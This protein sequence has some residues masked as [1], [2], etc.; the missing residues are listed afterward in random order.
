MAERGRRRRRRRRRLPDSLRTGWG[1][2]IRRLLTYHTGGIVCKSSLFRNCGFAFPSLK[3]ESVI[4][5][6]LQTIVKTVTP[7]L[8]TDGELRVNFLSPPAPPPPSATVL[9]LGDIFLNCLLPP[10]RGR[11]YTYS[12]TFLG[13]N[14]VSGGHK[15]GE[16]KG[17]KRRKWRDKLGGGATDGD[18]DPF[19]LPPLFLG[20]VAFHRAEGTIQ[21]VYHL[22]V[23]VQCG[24]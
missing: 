11:I 24:E 12:S 4:N 8:F 18:L 3:S 21:N 14:P 13:V 7:F 22:G 17:G 1:G 10:P 9:C 20:V 23:V 6:V 2:A 16:E 19:A 15:K 5:V